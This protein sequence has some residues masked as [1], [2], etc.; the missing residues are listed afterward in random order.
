MN[1]P[2]QPSLSANLALLDSMFGSSAD[3]YAKPLRIAGVRAAI[4]LFDNL[5]SLQ[6][7]W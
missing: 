2:L 7:L 6:A 5:S 3:Y 4:V 1:Q